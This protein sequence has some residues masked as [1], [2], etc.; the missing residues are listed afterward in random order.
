MLAALISGG[1]GVWSGAVKTVFGLAAWVFG[2]LA[3]PLVGGLLSS[4]FDLGQLPVWVLYVIA[5]LA[6]FVAVRFA[7][8]LVLKGVQSVGLGGVDRVF[9]GVLGLARAGLLVLV[10]AVV[11]HRL[12]F[13]QAPAWRNAM[14]LPLLDIMV[15]V[16]EPWLPARPAPQPDGRPARPNS[17]PAPKPPS[18]STSG[19]RPDS[20]SLRPLAAAR[21]SPG[22]GS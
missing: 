12:G 15:Q 7:G 19:R 2:V 9:G 22:N 1:F 16:A 17:R 14:S 6:T 3:A 4:R 11:A 5:F 13:A 10:V 21:T 18:K 20:T 8:Y